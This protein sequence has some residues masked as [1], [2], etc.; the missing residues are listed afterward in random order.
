MI[1]VPA[2]SPIATAVVPIS[3]SI[4]I[5]AP[6]VPLVAAAMT[7]RLSTG[8]SVTTA[9]IVADMPISTVLTFAAFA[10]KTFCLVVTRLGAVTSSRLPSAIL[11]DSAQV[12][13]T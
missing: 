8:W 1:V 5:L 4:S 9:S 10:I 3:V 12:V 7:A 11:F 13:N 2:V 6:A